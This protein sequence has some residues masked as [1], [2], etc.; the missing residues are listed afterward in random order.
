MAKSPRSAIKRLNVPTP[1]PAVQHD[2]VVHW[3]GSAPRLPRPSAEGCCR[4]LAPAT[5]P[6]RLGHGRDLPIGRQGE[7]SRPP[8][9]AGGLT[10]PVRTSTGT[11]PV[12]V[13]PGFLH[14]RVAR[15]GSGGVRHPLPFPQRP[16]CTAA[17]DDGPDLATEPPWADRCRGQAADHHRR[18]ADSAACPPRQPDR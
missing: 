13:R 14:M 15:H 12:V 7:G 3:G 6:S 11:T 17:R 16:G 9:A 4:Q 10:V 8:S 5:L 18:Q 1:R 2:F